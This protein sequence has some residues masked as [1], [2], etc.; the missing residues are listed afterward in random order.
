MRVQVLGHPMCTLINYDLFNGP[1]L[2]VDIF[3]DQPDNISD[4]RSQSKIA[5]TTFGPRFLV[6]GE[7]MNRVTKV[8]H[9]C[10]PNYPQRHER[11]RERK[12]CTRVT[13]IS[14]FEII[15]HCGVQEEKQIIV[16]WKRQWW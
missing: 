7:N 6:G 14:N 15:H 1:F 2:Y 11:E 9:T 12:K 13:A 4:L 3:M 16:G 10:Y 5:L 8:H